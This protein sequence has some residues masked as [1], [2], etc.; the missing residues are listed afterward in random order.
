MA[1]SSQRNERAARRGDTLLERPTARFVAGW[2][3]A[4]AL[5]ALLAAAP[6]QQPLGDEP[7]VSGSAVASDVVSPGTSG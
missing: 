3:A 5:V 6:G 7:L 2:L 1:G 4:M